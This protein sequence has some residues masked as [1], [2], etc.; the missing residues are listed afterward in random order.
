M[1]ALIRHLDGQIRL[2]QAIR[3]GRLRLLRQPGW[4]PIEHVAHVSRIGP[5]MIWTAKK[6]AANGSSSALDCE[7][8]VS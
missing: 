6:V 4:R 3:R 8:K 1:T 2:I 7:Q 5:L